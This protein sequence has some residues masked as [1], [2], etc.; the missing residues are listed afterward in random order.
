[1]GN[2]RTAKPMRKETTEEIFEV[3]C[4]GEAIDT[5]QIL[6]EI[7]NV[8][9]EMLRVLVRI[10]AKMGGG[11]KFEAAHKKKE[12]DIAESDEGAQ[13]EMNGRTRQSFARWPWSVPV[14]FGGAVSTVMWG[15]LI[16]HAVLLGTHFLYG[17]LDEG[18]SKFE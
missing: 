15:T 1:M 3:N 12:V 4:V 10:D 16:L 11:R 8:L 13:M 9:R 2:V 14:E 17:K 18:T 7:K 5:A 6:A